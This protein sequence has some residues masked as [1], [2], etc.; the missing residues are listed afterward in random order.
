MTCARK[1]WRF[2]VRSWS[3][4]VCRDELSAIITLLIFK[5]LWSGWKWL[6]GIKIGLILPLLSC[7][8]SRE[9]TYRWEKCLQSYGLRL[10]NV[11]PYCT[12]LIIC[13]LLK[14]KI[15]LVPVNW[16]LQAWSRQSS[17]FLR[18]SQDYCFDKIYLLWQR[19]ICVKR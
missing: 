11:F 5:C 4:S 3:L 17:Y 7:D 8:M 15:L 13:S 18:W 9:R 10:K 6:T 14:M 19:S 12:A 16:S 1:P 2:T